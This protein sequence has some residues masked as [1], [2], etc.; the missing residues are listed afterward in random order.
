MSQRDHLFTSVFT[1]VWI[2]GLLQEQAWSLMIH[3]PGFLSDL[4][5]SE[6][7]IGLLYSV[8]AVFGLLLRPTLG[9]LMDNLGR[10]PVLLVA[11]FGNTLALA[12]LALGDADPEW[13]RDLVHCNEWQT[14][15]VPALLSQHET[16]PATLF[17]IHNLSYQGTRP[18]RGDESSLEAWFPGMT[19][20]FDAIVDPAHNDCI[21]P[22]AF[23]IRRADA[24]N[25]VSPTYAEEICR[26]SDPAR[27]F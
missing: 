26:P 11:G 6:T 5:A 14:G 1:M 25:T 13:T 16:R 27:G 21:N 24:V 18:L 17:T 12:A 20:D 15:L 8:S 4:G 10:R 9:R 7:G 23:A 3:F 22:M 2:A 19:T